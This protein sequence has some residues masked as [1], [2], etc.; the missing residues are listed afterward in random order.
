MVARRLLTPR[1]ADPYDFCGRSHAREAARLGLLGRTTTLSEHMEHGTQHA[2]RTSLGE[3]QGVVSLTGIM[4]AATYP[5]HSDINR[6]LAESNRKLSNRPPN[7]H[8][9]FRLIDFQPNL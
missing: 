8:L 4:M 3:E 7:F 1:A 2:W 5:K 6:Q 9:I